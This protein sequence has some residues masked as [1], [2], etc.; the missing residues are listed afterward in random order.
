ME[1]DVLFGRGEGTTQQSLDNV[2]FEKRLCRAYQP[3]HLFRTMKDG[4]NL[5]LFEPIGGRGVWK[6]EEYR[7]ISVRHCQLRYYKIN[8][9]ERTTYLQSAQDLNQ[10]RKELFANARPRGGRLSSTE[11]RR[12]ATFR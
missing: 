5:G 7:I 8:T 1:T 12:L 10:K 9:I 4:A 3:G 6:V 11:G 2:Q